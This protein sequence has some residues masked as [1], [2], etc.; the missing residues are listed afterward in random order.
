M[1]S[2]FDEINDE[3]ERENFFAAVRKWIPLFIAASFIALV[4]T[5][6][7]LFVS[8]RNEQILISQEK[9]YEQA[10]EHM[11]VGDIEKARV[12][13]NSLRK[14]AKEKGYGFLAA[15]QIASMEHRDF[16]ASLSKEPIK[17]IQDIYV[18]ILRNRFGGVSTALENFFMAAFDLS[19]M[20]HRPDD[21]KVKSFVMGRFFTPHNA[22]AGVGYQRVALADIASEVSSDKLAKSLA[23][24]VKFS[25]RS[26]MSNLA[27]IG[28][29]ASMPMEMD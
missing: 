9:M 23:N 8:Y 7:Y 10:L 17:R 4:F 29:Q 27:Y 6:S 1:A 22:W 26:W 24:W 18:D 14:S 11:K 28:E 2:A 15:L 3:I 21:G 20:N 16:K 5:A 25:D 12:L 13:F 19:K